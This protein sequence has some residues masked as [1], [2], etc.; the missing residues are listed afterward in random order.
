MCGYPAIARPEL[1]VWDC[2]PPLQPHSKLSTDRKSLG[3]KPYL[4]LLLLRMAL[5]V[6]IINA[7]ILGF[8]EFDVLTNLSN[9]PNPL[10]IRFFAIVDAV[11]EQWP[12]F[13]AGGYWEAMHGKMAGFYE[14]RIRNRGLNHRFFCRIIDGK[15]LL[16]ICYLCKPS[17]H[18]LKPKDYEKV[19]QIFAL[20]KAKETW[21]TR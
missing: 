10:Q 5:E 12:R 20:A 14:I 18:L 6:A 16:I 7:E 2:H 15:L 4:N 21:P 3:V 19:V 8:S 13:Q 11:A 9:S 1:G 17:G